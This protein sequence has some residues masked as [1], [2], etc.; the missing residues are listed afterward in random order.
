MTALEPLIAAEMVDRAAFGGS[1]Q[2][3]TG[4]VRNPGLRPLF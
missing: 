2:P 4:I 3:G 1:H